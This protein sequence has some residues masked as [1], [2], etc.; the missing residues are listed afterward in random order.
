MGA[1]AATS[2]HCFWHFFL[3]LLQARMSR[4]VILVLW[5]IDSLSQHAQQCPCPQVSSCGEDNNDCWLTR[6][7]TVKNSPAGVVH[8][9]WTNSGVMRLLT[10]CVPYPGLRSKWPFVFGSLV[11]VSHDTLPSRNNQTGVN[12]YD[13][14]RLCFYKL[15]VWWY[16]Y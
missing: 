12:T 15:A 6:L 10:T 5:E 8:F 11:P 9:Q 3:R 16:D 4:G 1:S 2:K 13:V 7:P 14:C